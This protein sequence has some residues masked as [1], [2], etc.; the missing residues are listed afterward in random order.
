MD[1]A[2]VTGVTEATL[3]RQNRHFAGTTGRSEENRHLGFRPA[4]MDLITRAIYESCFANGAP[5]PVHLLDGLPDHVVIAR[6]PAGRVRA[7]KE[8]I[9]AGFVRAGRFYTRDEAVRFAA[10]LVS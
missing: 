2:F 4:F 3:A 9:V 8:S 1:A 7:V 6:C 5:A 10:G